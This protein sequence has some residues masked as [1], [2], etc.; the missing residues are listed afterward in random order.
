[1]NTSFPHNIFEL[2]QRFGTPEACQQFLFDVR[3]PEGFTCPKCDSSQ[4]AMLT[5]RNHII[6]CS[7]CRFQ[8]SL[9][10]GTAMYNSHMDLCQWFIAAYLMTTVTPGISALQLQRQIGR[11]RYEPCF[12]MLHKLRSIMVRPNREKLSGEIEIDET[13]IGGHRIGPRGRGALGKSLVI[14]AVEKLPAGSGHTRAG[15]ARLLRV[16]SA[17]HGTIKKFLERY[18]EPETVVHSDGFKSYEG[19]EEYGYIHK[20]FT[21]RDPVQASKVF[22]HIHRVFGNLKAWIIGTFHGVSPKHMQAYL[23]EYAFRFNRR[24][25]PWN[26]FKSALGL[27]SEGDS[28]TYQQLYHTDEKGGWVHP[29]P[30]YAE[31]DL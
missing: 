18:V 25:D 24:Y 7:K 6:Q 28:P 27:A 31:V 8:M 29:N 16:E 23:N 13:L 20:P 5:T 19:I 9:T 12:N 21:L 30:L 15:R 4:Y 10:T 26:T 17:S 11:K 2:G 22:P 3:W 1:M 14:G